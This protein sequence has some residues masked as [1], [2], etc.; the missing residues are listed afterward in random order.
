MINKNVLKNM[1]INSCRMGYGA[2]VLEGYYGSVTES[3]AVKTLAYAIDRGLMIDTA[4]AYGNGHN[5]ILVSRALKESKEEPFIA[6]K[7]G[8]VFDETGR[9]TDVPT[10]WGFSLKIDGTPEYVK[11][12]IDASLLR[13][14]VDSVD[15]WYAHYPD[16]DVPIEETVGAMAEV[17]KAGKARAIG[18]SNVCADEIRRANEVFPVTAVQYEY[19]LWR[20]EAEKEIL[21]LLREIDGALVAWSP[22]GGGFF[23]GKTDIGKEDF[24]NS[25]PRY[26]GDNLKMNLK[27]YEPLKKIAAELGL[28]QSQLA[29]AWILNR[30]ED[31]YPIPGTRNMNRIDENLKAQEISLDKD[32][33]TQIDFIARPGTAEGGTLLK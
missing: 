25:N 11:S 23:T 18:L 9:G 27:N 7:S 6:T 13:L 5:E 8:I 26:Q 2:M 28:S 10:G 16:P 3:D 12:S 21:P 17:V 4:D 32:V 33:M 1:V 22:L 31:I 20:R 29:L 15:L 14:G 30:E 19:S 24:R